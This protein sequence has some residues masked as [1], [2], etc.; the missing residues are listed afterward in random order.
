MLVGGLAGMTFE[1]VLE[2]DD[3][4]PENGVATTR[5]GAAP[6]KHMS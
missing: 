3:Y 5:F 2:R 6:V 4:A 1:E